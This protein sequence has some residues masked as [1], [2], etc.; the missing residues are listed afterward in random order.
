MTDIKRGKCDFV[1]N[2]A[3]KLLNKII[4][5]FSINNSFVYE[6]CIMSDP[7]GSIIQRVLKSKGMSVAELARRMHITRENLYNLF[8]RDNIDTKQLQKIGN[9]LEHN[10]FTYFIT[11]DFNIDGINQGKGNMDVLEYQVEIHKLKDKIKSLEKEIEYLKK[12]NDLLEK[13][14]DNNA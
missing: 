13:K 11:N 2:L 1:N 9:I 6:I 12:I 7:I 14:K 8:K 10:F 5:W 4:H 3:T